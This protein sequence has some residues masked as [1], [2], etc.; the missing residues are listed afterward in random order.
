MKKVLL[1]LMVLVT[2]GTSGVF[3]VEDY[4]EDSL[5]F[6]TAV[7]YKLASVT[8][9]LDQSSIATIMTGGAWYCTTGG[10]TRSWLVL[11]EDSLGMST[12][13]GNEAPS[14]IMELES[15]VHTLDL[16][17]HIS[18]GSGVAIN[19]R[20]QVLIHYNDDGGI[21]EA[22]SGITPI[23]SRS[24]LS[25][26]AA[27]IVPGCTEVVNLSGRVVSFNPPQGR[28]ELSNLSAGTYLARTQNDRTIK[29]VKL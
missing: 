7:T 3:M 1:V 25:S 19:P 16:M 26:G 11:N 29:I 6:P 8:F 5:Y 28:I 27:V 24:V 23:E 21:S 13:L 4:T 10:K 22:S 20:L 17:V 14:F 9:Q 12:S 18:G 15:G 2:I